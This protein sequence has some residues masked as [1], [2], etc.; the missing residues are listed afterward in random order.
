MP[1]YRQPPA[2]ELWL[3]TTDLSSLRAS[4]AR[5]LANNGAAGGDGMSVARFAEGVTQRLLRL[6]GT[7][8]SDRWRPGP[9]RAVDIPKRKGGTRRLMIPPVPDRVVHGAVGLS[10]TPILEPQFSDASFAYRPGRSVK[11][12]L[13]AVARWRDRGF[14]HVV[15]ADIVSFFDNVRHDRLLS[16]LDVALAGHKGAGRVVDLVALILEGQAQDSGVAGRGVPQGSPLSPLLSNLYLDALDDAIDD[17]GL[18]LIRYGDD[19]IILAR[20][21]DSAE[22]ALA[23]AREVLAEEGLEMHA[24]GSRVRDFD[25]GFEFLGDLFVRGLQ[26]QSTDEDREED[27]VSALRAV[28]EADAETE[29]RTEHE[30]RAGYDRGTRVLHVTEPGRQLLVEGHVFAV[31]ATGGHL[32]AGIA[33]SRVGRIEIGSGVEVSWEAQRLALRNDVPM[34]IVGPRG[35]TAAMWTPRG[36]DRAGLHLAQARAAL[37]GDFATAVTR[38]L[39]D[40]RIRNMRTQLFRLNRKVADGEVTAAL[41]TLKRHL[42]KLQGF[43]DVAALRGAEG[44]AAA[45]FWPALGRL[46]D[47]APVPF[48]RRRP[49]TDPLNAAINYLTGILE[50]DVAQSIGASGLHPGFGFLHAA[51]DGNWALV[52]DLMEPFRTPLTEGIAAY[53]FNARRLRPEMFEVH[54]KSVAIDPAGRRALVRGYETAATRVVN[55]PGRGQRLAWRPMMRWQAQRL[56]DAVEQQDPALFTPYLMEP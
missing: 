30:G 11:Q 50:R 34:A 39:V 27:P 5:V 13:A 38:A 36:M 10:L 15:E 12:A 19:F 29:E 44:H 17:K 52:W 22:A 16:K 23:E 56:A 4:W 37:D 49:A 25:R 14:W 46:A 32:L 18:R 28:A 26:M 51:R 8:R 55:V 40:A 43:A 41:A 48:R 33:P 3:A 45:L 7:L 54:P 6:S 35:E 9:A 42:A 31:M 20:K 53:L 21:R 1:R 2:D 47:G 24:A